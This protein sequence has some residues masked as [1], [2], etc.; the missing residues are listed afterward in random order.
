METLRGKRDKSLR[1]LLFGHYGSSLRCVYAQENSAF[2]RRI[3]AG[4]S[5]IAR[6]SYVYVEGYPA[7]C[8]KDTE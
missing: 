7:R 5:Q 6:G 3:E 4:N 1:N 2:Y 8:L